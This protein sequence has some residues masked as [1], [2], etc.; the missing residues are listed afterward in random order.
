MLQRNVPLHSPGGT[1]NYT[2]PRDTTSTVPRAASYDE[3]IGH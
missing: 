2:V 1:A 3:C